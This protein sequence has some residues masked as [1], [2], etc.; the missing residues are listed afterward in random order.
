MV[1][2]FKILQFLCYL[3]VAYLTVFILAQATSIKDPTVNGTNV[4]KSHIFISTML[5]LKKGH[6]AQWPSASV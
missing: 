6:V 1:H 3:C 4:Y 2:Y 5:L